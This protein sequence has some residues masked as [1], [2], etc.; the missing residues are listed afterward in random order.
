[1]RLS[2][3]LMPLAAGLMMTFLAVTPLRAQGLD[4]ILQILVEVLATSVQAEQHEEAA[5][6][7]LESELAYLETERERVVEDFEQRRRDVKRVAR[8]SIEDIEDQ[9]RRKRERRHRIREVKRWRD[10][11][12][13]RLADAESWRLAELDRRRAA[14]E[15]RYDDRV[16]YDY[17]YDYDHGRVYPGRRQVGAYEPA[18]TRLLGR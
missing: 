2:R 12:L 3:H 13:A 5:R 18:V 4:P 16:E 1:M 15:R 17:D 6:R 11:E 10:R 8:R 14:A 7:D 9:V